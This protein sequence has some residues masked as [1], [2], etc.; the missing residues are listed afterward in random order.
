MDTMSTIYGDIMEYERFKS[1]VSQL[2]GQEKHPVVIGEI[3]A[4][5]RSLRETRVAGIK[6]LG[7]H[8]MKNLQ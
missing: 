3:T 4:V 7:Q 8:G 6:K 2:S 5:S 1:E